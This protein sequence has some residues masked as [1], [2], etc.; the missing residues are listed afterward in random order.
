MKNKEEVES[1]LL[2][3]N[4]CQLKAMITP[5][6]ANTNRTPKWLALINSHS[7]RPSSILPV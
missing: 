5:I 6:K 3:K 7:F 4:D 2:R 1:D